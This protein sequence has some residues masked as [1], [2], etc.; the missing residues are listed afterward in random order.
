MGTPGAALRVDPR[1]AQNGQRAFPSPVDSPI[2]AIARGVGRQVVLG[3]AD[4]SVRELEAVVDEEPQWRSVLAAGAGPVQALLHDRAGDLW[5]LAGGAVRRLGTLRA[6]WQAD[7][8][9]QP[10]MPAGNHDHI[11]ARIGDRLY[12]A[13]GK[14]FFG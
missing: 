11:F 1:A 7:W 4:G 6:P 9:E 3:F 8:E 10:R 13:G 2:T 14:T 12:T 5:V